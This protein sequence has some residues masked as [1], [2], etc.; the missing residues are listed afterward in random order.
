MMNSRDI[1]RDPSNQL[2]SALSAFLLLF[3]SMSESEV[4]PSIHLY[5]LFFSSLFFN[6]GPVLPF[7]LY[8]TF[9]LRVTVSQNF[10]SFPSL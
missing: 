10:P 9:L 5:N 2:T 1:N 7:P 6:L 8:K 3:P 4:H